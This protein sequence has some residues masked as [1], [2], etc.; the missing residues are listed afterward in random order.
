MILLWAVIT[1]AILYGAPVFSRGA[2]RG[3]DRG[4]AARNGEVSTGD[5]AQ[6][7]GGRGTGFWSRKEVWTAGLMGLFFLMPHLLHLFAMGDQSWGA[8][9]AKFSTEFFW[10]NLSVN[11]PYYLNNDLFPAAFTAL[12]VVGL[13]FARLDLRWRLMVFV[14]FLLFWGIFLFFYA[15]SYKYGAD[16]RFALV[17]F[18][19]IAVLAGMGGERIRS[20]IGRAGSVGVNGKAAGVMIVL[21]L[22]FTWM[23]YVPL[24]R[25]V[26][27][28][29]WGARYDHHHAREF[30]KKI[31][32]RSIVLSHN[33]TMFLVWGQNAIQAYAGARNPE[34]VQ[35]LME[36]YQGHVYF[37]YSYWCNIPTDG[38]RQLC[39][40]VMARYNMEEIASASEQTYRYGLYKMIK[41]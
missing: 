16:V 5:A 36:T 4:S 33:A 14:W 26:G 17:S 10:N 30:I 12:A 20:W 31:P 39:E 9:G 15:G 8:T 13:L 34:I 27:Q 38:N 29:A 22:I 3:E 7:A 1:V 21:V 24:V 28:E 35:N 23:P 6:K 41:K 2:R 40:A 32:P 19:P 25:A 18:M 37:H 11:G